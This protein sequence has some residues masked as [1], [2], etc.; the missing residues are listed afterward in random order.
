MTVRQTRPEEF[1]DR[2]IFMSMFKDI[3]WTKNRSY[4]ECFFEFCKVKRFRE[5]ISVGTLVFSRS[6]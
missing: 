3:D 5:K 6:W 4:K 2:I 1:D